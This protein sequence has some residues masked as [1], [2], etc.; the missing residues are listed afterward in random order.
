MGLRKTFRNRL[1]RMRARMRSKSRSGSAAIE[2]A[3]VAP[4]LF[5][6]ILGTIE[7]G[8][9]FFA[10]SA[11]QNATDDTARLIRTGQLS[12]TMTASELKTQI[13]SE[14]TGLISSTNCNEN[15]QV[16]L[17]SYSN[18]GSASYGSVTKKD[19]SLDST[20]MSVESTGSCD[21]VLLRTFYPWTVMTPMMSALLANMPNGQFLM[22]SAA[23]FRTEPYLSGT[24]C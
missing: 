12:G 15:L 19:G 3:F 17:H 22:A 7:T 20:K 5:L 6:F 8:V 1:S 14:I 16:D 2:F 21:V 13:C 23:A 9:L 24:T 4:V 18:F 10:S 11:L